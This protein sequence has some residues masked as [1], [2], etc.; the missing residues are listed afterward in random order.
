M[1][2]VPEACG[3]GLAQRDPFVIRDCLALDAGLPPGERKDA[4]AVRR[5]VAAGEAVWGGVC[6]VR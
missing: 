3:E 2:D 4:R 5:W 6:P 1:Q